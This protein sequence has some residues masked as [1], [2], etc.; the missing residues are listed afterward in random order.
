MTDMTD[1]LADAIRE[2]EDLADRAEFPVNLD[3]PQDVLAVNHQVGERIDLLKELSEA[4]TNVEVLRE[5]IE[6]ESS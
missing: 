2:A 5:E 3:D 1:Q 6:A 4:L